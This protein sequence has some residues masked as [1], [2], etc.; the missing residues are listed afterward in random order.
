[1]KIGATVYIRYQD[2]ALFRNV[3][4]KSQRPI[5]QEAMG[6]LDHEDNDYIRVIL[7][8]YREQ[9]VQDGPTE[10]KATGLVILRSTI[11]EMRKIV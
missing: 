6:W 1:M 2:H 4:P 8:Q 9:K 5:I 3:D 11:L 7:A 10:I